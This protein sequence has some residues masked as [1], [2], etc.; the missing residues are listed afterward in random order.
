[1]KVVA[2]SKGRSVAEIKKLYD[3]GYRDFGE[4]RVPE[5]LEKRLLL[6]AD[7]RWHFIG[8]LQSNKVAKLVGNCALIHSVDSIGLAEKISSV[9]DAKGIVTEILLQVNTSGETTKQGFS[10]SELLQSY[11]QIAELPAL[12]I[13]GL[14]T[15]A[16]KLTAETE[17][18]VRTTFSRLRSLKETLKLTELSMGMSDDYQIAL[19]EGA[20]IIRLGRALFTS[21]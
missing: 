2:V 19:D 21:K 13:C 15:M 12:L 4:N 16:P 6:P 10:E 8:S 11:P 3:E 1:M 17:E 18:R 9:S 5:L 14:M 7:I 20:T